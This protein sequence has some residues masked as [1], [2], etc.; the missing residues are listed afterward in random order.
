MGG[1]VEYETGSRLKSVG[2]IFYD[3][4]KS[5]DSVQNELSALSAVYVC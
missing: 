5:P 3:S 1:G 2:Q 4:T